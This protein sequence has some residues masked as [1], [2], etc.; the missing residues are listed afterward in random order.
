[1]ERRTR[2]A[3]DGDRFLVNGRPT[4]EGR[5]YRGWPVEGLLLNSR[6]V[7]AIFDDRNPETRGRWAYPDT[8]VWDPE[9]NVAEFLAMLPEYRRSGL[10]AVTLNL[11]GGSPEGYSRAQP[12]HNSAFAADGALDPAYLDR[13]RRVLDRLDSLGM[14]AIVGLF[15][16]GQD[17]RLADEAAVRR[18]VE[19]AV[20]WLLD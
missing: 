19:N 12:W 15:Y 7:Q 18:G 2:L 17:E 14:V 9:R 5:V 20:G 13:L 6:M 8:G 3:I 10:L 1:M 4:Y 11:Q 16:F